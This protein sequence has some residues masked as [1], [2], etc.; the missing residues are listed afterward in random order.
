MFAFIV[1]AS[2]RFICDGQAEPNTR[3][4]IWFYN[5]EAPEPHYYNYAGSNAQAG[6]HLYADQS[7]T[8]YGGGLDFTQPVLDAPRETKLKVGGLVSLKK[9]EFRSLWILRV[10]ASITGVR[11]RLGQHFPYHARAVARDMLDLP[12]GTPIATR[13]P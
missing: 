10:A 7:E 8:A 13:G 11:V 9:R 6:G 12:M 5:P 4:T 1:S 3:D 2:V